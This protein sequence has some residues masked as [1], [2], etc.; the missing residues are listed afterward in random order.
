MIK[1]VRITNFKS[2]GD[3]SVQ[4][5]PVT[6]LIGRSGT[7]K[8]NFLDALRF[9]RDC[10]ASRSG[11]TAA[12][13]LGGWGRVTPATAKSSVAT[14]F[15][16]RFVGPGAGEEFEYYAVFQQQQP[17]P[18]PQLT[19]EKLSLG[20]RVLFHRKSGSWVS[21]PQVVNATPPNTASLMLGM[22]T[23]IR[24]INRAHFLL[25]S[26]L[27]FYAFPDDTLLPSSVGQTPG[28]TQLQTGLFQKGENYL[29]VLN[30]MD[31]DPQAWDHQQELVAALRQLNSSIKSVDLNM[32]ARDKI[33]ISHD[34]AGRILPLELVYES[35]GLRRL[36][37]HLI[38]LYQTPLKQTLFFE[39]PE[40]G[41][42]PGAL[43]VLAE[44]FKACPAGGRGQVILTSHSPD[45]LDHFQPEQLRVVEI[46]D[47]LTKIGRVA[48]EQ[49]EAIREQLMSPGEL[50]T[51]DAARVAEPAGV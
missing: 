50:L 27:A 32:P 13:N 8:S 46:E 29:Q 9:L 47:Y 28:L 20:T 36:L 4:L 18:G 3:V 23:G 31:Y 39:E 12:T 11:E 33:V 37:A 17:Y 6:V 49:V 42:H 40:K 35:E 26:G 38:A 43:E 34:V 48:S 19:E 21:A 41:I 45:L 5:E 44:Q 30:A 15:L 16:V 51:V 14:S 1:F 25:G 24:E 7:G 22:I 10:V 2:L